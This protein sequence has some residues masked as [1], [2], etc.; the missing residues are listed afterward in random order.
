MPRVWRHLKWDFPLFFEQLWLLNLYIADLHIHFGNRVLCDVKQYIKRCLFPLMST[1]V[2]DHER[3]PCLWPPKSIYVNFELQSKSVLSWRECHKVWTR[4]NKCIEIERSVLCE[5]SRGCVFP[6][7]CV[8][9]NDCNVLQTC[10]SRRNTSI[11]VPLKSKSS[12][13]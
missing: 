8:A 12:K 5:N 4:I 6:N 11:H 9:Q 10:I 3:F 1:H 13:N 2:P 7:E